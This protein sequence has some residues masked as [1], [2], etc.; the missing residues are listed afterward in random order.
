MSGH[1][2]NHKGS[3]PIDFVG[4]NAALLR[5][6]DTLLAQWLPA[7][8]KS[9]DRWYVGDFD[10]GAGKS[11]NVN[12]C[13]GQW[14]DN[15][16]HSDCGHDLISLYARVQGLN[17]GQAAREL[18]RQQGWLREDDRQPAPRHSAPAVQ[19]APLPT[20]ADAAQEQR[21]PAP[22]P[23]KRKSQWRAITPVPARVPPPSWRFG[24]K[25]EKS[26]QWVEME[27]V[28]TWAYRLDGVLYGHVARFERIASSGKL[29][30]ETMPRTWCV[31]ESDDQGTQ[32]WHWKQ[33]E[34][35]RPLYVPA[36][37]LADASR[38]VVLVEGEKCAEAGHQLLGAEYDFVTWPGG[39]KTWA[40]AGW[41]WL[42]GRT[43][44]MWP[45]CDAQRERLSRAEREAGADPESK[46]IKPEAEQPGL[47]AMVNVG[48]LLQADYGCTVRMCKIPGPGAVAAGWDIADAIEQGWGA[49][50]VRAMIEQA[51]DFKPRSPEALAKQGASLASSA[52]AESVEV[53]E[54]RDAW[55]KH[56]QTTSNG[57]V[58]PCRENVVL[59][60]DGLP[61]KG[62][63]G[64]PEV[65]GCIA[66]NEFTNSVV[67]TRQTPWGT[68]AGPWDES[69]ELELGNYL[70]HVHWLPPC[71]RQTLEEAVTMVARRHRYH[72][73]R[74]Y[75]EAQRGTWDGVPR[76]ASWLARITLKGPLDRD[77]PRRPYLA[78]VGTWMMMAIVDRVLN[79]GCKFDY[80]PI[81][82]SRQQ[83]WG[84]STLC[85]ILGGEWFADTG[86][87]LGDKDS[88]QNLQGILVY[89]WGELDSLSK[90]EITKVKQFISSQKDRFR[91]S[92]DRRPKDYPRQ[93][94]FI[95]TTNESHYLTDPTGNRRFWPIRLERPIDLAWVREFLPQL[96]AEALHYLER[97]DRY[98]PTVSEQREL[99]DPQ[100][101]ERAVESSLESAIRKF[102]YD[103]G[104]KI[105]VTGLNGSLLN[106]IALND[107]L[108]AVGLTID[109]QTPAQVKQASAALGRLGWE[110][111]RATGKG[112]DARPYLYHRPAELPDDVATAGKSGSGQSDDRPVQGDQQEGA[113]DDC[114]F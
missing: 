45:D 5:Q 60:L 57:S 53:V 84:K 90:S 66:F 18:M 89:E 41:E 50:Q 70:T 96:Y 40:L 8:E 6:V 34:A 4:L 55:R 76:L 106:S 83:G 68:P 23:A 14:I 86:L 109:K 27:A 112:G 94:V 56:L 63:T 42:R 103:D 46:P 78:R 107:L 59:A 74:Q 3:Q 13:T 75:F 113:D 25:D 62:I 73:A 95:G 71:S 7:G 28:R 61:D 48:T 102:L 104:Q 16:D 91:A 24:Y 36:E 10:G 72:P 67:K 33:W 110:R 1:H 15:A 19:E 17:N 51:A 82:E 58:R 97:G 39:C 105:S 85:A 52:V 92:F 30:K 69:D 11:A 9:N 108:S 20:D 38:T 98:Y 32:R 93:V 64:V 65:L 2:N 35:P 47:A 43:V 101:N 79:P 77:D 87:V 29:V 111:K 99:F 44:I 31:D 100:Q 88:Y 21:A 22:A 37:T 80:M 49:D 81:F 26:H 114:P 12:M 54:A